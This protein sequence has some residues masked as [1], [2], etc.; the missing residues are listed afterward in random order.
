M[1]RFQSGPALVVMGCESYNKPPDLELKCK[2]KAHN[3]WLE[4]LAGLVMQ[5]LQIGGSSHP[6]KSTWRLQLSL[7]EQLLYLE[8]MLRQPLQ[9]VLD[10][11]LILLLRLLI[12]DK[13]VA[14]LRVI[15]FLISDHTHKNSPCGRGAGDGPYYAFC[16]AIL[17]TLAT[18]LVTCRFWFFWGWLFSYN[19]WDNLPVKSANVG[20]GDL[21]P[22]LALQ[23]SLIT[24][25]L[26]LSILPCRGARSTLF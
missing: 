22:F 23:N 19:Q 16:L 12:R 8:V 2:T 9:K 3:P 17:C 21:F 11:S 1:R 18:S 24:C 6:R 5:Y 4:Q 15:L 26:C 25:F 10:F 14:C 7:P 13:N 20:W